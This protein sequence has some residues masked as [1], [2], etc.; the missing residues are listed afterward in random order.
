MSQFWTKILEY[1]LVRKHVIGATFPTPTLELFFI[2]LYYG[3]MLCERVTVTDGDCRLYNL[4]T[5]HY[6]TVNIRYRKSDLHA[7]LILTKLMSCLCPRNEVAILWRVA[8]CCWPII[9]H[10]LELVWVL[11]GPK[12]SKSQ[13]SPILHGVWKP[14]KFVWFVNGWNTMVDN[15]HSF[16]S[17]VFKWLVIL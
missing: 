16:S 1:F 8:Y 14:D 5:C 2:I 12:E 17:L 4:W 15:S 10:T 13:M 9:H 11:N 6:T 3:A 7:Q